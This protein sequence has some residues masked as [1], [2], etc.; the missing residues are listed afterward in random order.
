MSDWYRKLFILK[1]VVIKIF[2]SFE[3]IY[4]CLYLG[5]AFLGIDGSDF[6]FAFLLFEIVM[7]VKTLN[8]VLNAIRNPIKELMLT[9]ILWIILVYYFSLVAYF[10]FYDSFKENDCNNL[11]KCLSIIFYQN[12]KNDNGIASYLSPIISGNDSRNPFQWRFFFDQFFN[13]IVKILIVQIVSGIIIDNFAKLRNDE[14]EMIYD[15]NNICTICSLERDKI[16]KIY[17]KFGKSYSSHIKE[18]HNMFNYVYY[19][20]NIYNKDTTE[21]TGM[22]SYI[23]EMVFRQK[24]ITWIPLNRMYYLEED[25]T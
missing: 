3:I 1:G 8:N 23:Y 5:F 2:L 4:Y 10:F 12:I 9:L 16:E 14:I 21:F 6:F 20:I 17:E 19:I 22:E 13:L 11:L 7:R 18:D 24:D 15:M 25:T